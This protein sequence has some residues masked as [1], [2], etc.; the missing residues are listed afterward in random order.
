[1][2]EY[3]KVE[4]PF[5]GKYIYQIASGQAVSVAAQALQSYVIERF[6]TDEMSVLEVGSGIGIVSI[7]LA[8]QRPQWQISGIEIQAKL[9]DIA[10]YNAQLCDV[11]V[12]FFLVDLRSF[13][14]GKYNLILS[15]P[16]WLKLGSGLLS[17]DAGK[18]MS[19]FEITCTT[20]D[21]C[22]LIR[23]SLSA[24]GRAVLL[25]PDFRVADIILHAQKSSLD[26]LE[27]FSVPDS[28]GYVILQLA[29]AKH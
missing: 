4:L 27:R 25:Y 18:N 28:K 20:A 2:A 7:M 3:T 14:K 12:D 1:M 29:L 6:G 24:A 5:D 23:R 22:E 17:P 9:C 11:E 26:I 19:R 8:L 10:R 13:D 16:P 15:N 21:I